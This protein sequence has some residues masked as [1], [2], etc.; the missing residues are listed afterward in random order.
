M[1]ALTPLEIETLPEPVRR[2][3]AADAPG[4]VRLLAARGMAPLAPRELVTALYQLAE[5]WGADAAPTPEA[6]AA[7]ETAG[8]LPEGVLSGA[9]AA[10][11]DARVLDWFARRL[12][13]RPPIV[14]VI[15]F[16]KATADETFA[17][18]ASLCR[19]AEV[20]AIA[21][22]EQRLLR[23]PPIIAALYLNPRTPM[24]VASRALELAIRNGVHVDGVPNFEEVRASL[25]AEGGKGSASGAD[26]AVA[27]NA[28]EPDRPE[29]APAPP[30]V[31]GEPA[32][33]Q[34][35]P[36]E[37]EEATSIG[38]MSMSAKL[39]L[40]SVGNAFARAVLIRDSNRVIQMAVIRS[41]AIK[42]NEVERFAGNR[43]LSE[44]VIRYI[45][46]QRHFLRLYGVK[47]G[48]V[49]NPK[50]P[51]QASMGILPHLTP[52]DLKAISRSK[53]VPSALAKAAQGLIAKR[54]PR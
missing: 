53:G 29:P 49:N 12:H 10:D 19:D 26:D 48:L 46:S 8:G 13:A 6:E 36:E 38:A 54:E 11:L 43:G 33:E 34:R 51:L 37:E 32:E 20:Q 42:D 25:I 50:C 35:T 52:R 30:V 47:L 22:N 23:H 28:S 4:P 9:L 15:L 21:R 2:V 7:R 41:P 5:P 44:D 27:K 40:A 16:N 45:A 24:S 17:H 31:D 14:Q 1:L 3:V 39:R 18:L